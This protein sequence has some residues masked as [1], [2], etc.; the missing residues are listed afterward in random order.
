MPTHHDHVHP[1]A[2]GVGLTNTSTMLN[3]P[4]TPPPENQPAEQDIGRRRRHA[5][6]D[7]GATDDNTAAG[8]ALQ[9][10]DSAY[11][12]PASSPNPSTIDEKE[13][14]LN[15]AES[16][17]PRIESFKHSS[18]PEPSQLRQDGSSILLQSQVHVD[19]EH[20]LLASS[21]SPETMR[22]NEQ[23]PMDTDISMTEPKPSRPSHIRTSKA[24]ELPCGLAEIDLTLD[25]SSQTRD[26]DF[27]YKPLSPRYPS[28]L[29]KAYSQYSGTQQSDKQRYNVDVTIL[30]VDMEQCT[31]SGYLKIRDLTPEHEMLQTFFTGEI[32]GGPN[33]KYTFRT[34]D[35]SWG[36]TDRTDL[37]H[38][39]RFPA[40]RHLGSY[41]KRDM[42]FKFPL[43]NEPWWEQE[44]IFMR[45]KEHFLVP[46]HKTRS[47][48]GASFEGFYYICLNQLQG[49]IS[50]IYFHSKSEK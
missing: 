38:W 48:Q 8:M 25:R 22:D 27:T 47:I 19:V 17:S 4:L 31:L 50:G 26:W 30:T 21:P 40:W 20:E 39:A 5:E 32:I 33:Q 44:N 14:I 7:V 49:R 41:A 1:V 29:F 11:L 6:C 34:Q 16:V 23:D 35:R 28:S 10:E 18:E 9:Q 37:M 3:P 36:A 12:S 43:D 2:L 15:T 24:G 13:R 42:N 46:D 45:W